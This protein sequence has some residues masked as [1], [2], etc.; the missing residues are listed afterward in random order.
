MFASVPIRFEPFIP[1]PF[2]AFCSPA[3]S[4]VLIMAKSTAKSTVA[5]SGQQVAKE[6]PTCRKKHGAFC[7]V[8]ARYTKVSTR[9]PFTNTL[10]ENYQK[11]FGIKNL[12]NSDYPF[13]G[14]LAGSSSGS[15]SSLVDLSSQLS[16]SSWIVFIGQRTSLSNS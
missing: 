16:F 7:F 9:K 10:K 11:Q 5:K 13:A 2:I 8:C 1:D 4:I 6:G 3:F 12:K 14:E 15:L